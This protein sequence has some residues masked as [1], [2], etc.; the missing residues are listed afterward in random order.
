[1]YPPSGLNSL[2]LGSSSSCKLTCNNYSISISFYLIIFEHTKL[3]LELSSKISLDSANSGLRRLHAPHQVLWM[4]TMIG[5]PFSLD[6][7][8]ASSNVFHAKLVFIK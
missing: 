2:S 7:V 3:N 1:M 5:F 4:I 8:R 6:K